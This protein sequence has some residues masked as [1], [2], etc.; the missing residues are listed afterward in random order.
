M[1]ASIDSQKDIE[2]FLLNNE[3]H[4]LQN[5]TIEGTLIRIEQPKIQTTLNL[6]L[7]EK[8]SYERGTGIGFDI[9]KYYNPTSVLDAFMCNE[10][11]QDLKTT[12]QTSTRHQLRNG[13]K[14]EIYIIETIRSLTKIRYENLEF[15]KKNK[16]NF[17][18]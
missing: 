17:L 16:N 15:Y 13:S 9:S 18:G 5:Q 10:L 4:L 11:Y 1:L 6:S 2:V 3:L 7:N 8:R 12:G 14:I